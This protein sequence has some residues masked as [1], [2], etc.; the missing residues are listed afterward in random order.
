MF[1]CVLTQ[2][3]GSPVL[4]A[5]SRLHETLDTRELTPGQHLLLAPD[6]NHIAAAHSEREVRKASWFYT[7][8]ATDDTFRN[9]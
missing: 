9:L 1:W 3:Q 2:A 4:W 7:T 5:A 6:L 8:D